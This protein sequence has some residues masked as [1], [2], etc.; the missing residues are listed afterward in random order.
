MRA[1]SK[2]PIDIILG[3]NVYCEVK[4]EED[5]VDKPVEPTVE[6]TTFGWVI[7]GGE[8]VSS[9]Y[10]YT[11]VVSENEKLYSLDVLRVEDRGKSDQLDVYKE[12]REHIMRQSDGRYEVKIPWI[13]GSE[14]SE[15]NESWSRKRLQNGE[16]K[17]EKNEE[18]GNGYNEMVIS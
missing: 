12:F 10:M 4:T 5:F 2:Y 16:G 7:H 3:N 11:K 15:I 1:N 8:L 13:T 6:G 17:L 18:L 9:N 14:L